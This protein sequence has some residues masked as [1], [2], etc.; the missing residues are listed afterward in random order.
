M[1]RVRAKAKKKAPKGKAK[2]KAKKPKAKKPTKKATP[3]KKAPKTSGGV[4]KSKRKKK[5]GPKAPRGFV[6]VPVLETQDEAFDVIKKRLDDAQLDAYEG[7]TLGS[8]EYD[9]KREVFRFDS[10]ARTHRYR[11]GSIDGEWSVPV[12]HGVP[13]EKLTFAMEEAFG[14]K[15]LGITYFIAYGVR[16][17]IQSD[18]EIYQEFKGMNQIMTHYHRAEKRSKVVKVFITIRKILVTLAK[19]YR[20]KPS[21]LFIRLHWNP[22]NEKPEK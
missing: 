5:A 6:P 11:D 20:R 16:Y 14:R 18:D 13:A 2:P 17:V 21:L 1:P 10:K 3:R 7:V 15:P 22:D 8:E 12:P 9:G 19:K 4:G